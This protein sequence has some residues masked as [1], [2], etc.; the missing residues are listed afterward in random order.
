MARLKKSQELEDS[1]PELP[2]GVK[3][4]ESENT[5]ADGL[6]QPKKV[7]PGKWTKMTV[8]EVMAA[9]EEGI[10]FGYNP[11]TGEGLIKEE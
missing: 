1:V 7:Y 8:K 9:Q 3:Q 6:K 2:E 10:L 4:V 5:V 11:D